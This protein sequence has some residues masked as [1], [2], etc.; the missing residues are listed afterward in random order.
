MQP[1]HQQTIANAER[2]FAA[3][4]NVI[5]LLVGG[6]LAHGFALERS[7]VDIMIIVTPEEYQ[8]RQ[9]ANELLYLDFENC[10]YEGG[11]ID[12][13]YVDL[14]YIELVAERGSE[15][16]RYAF[17]DA[18]VVF[19]RDDRVP[20]LLRRAAR[21]PVE[22]QEA[23]IRR[24]LGQLNAWKWMAQEGRKHAN[25]YLIQRAVD[26]FVLF[27]VRVILAHNQRL[28]PFH[29]WML[30]ELDHASDQPDGMRDR[31]DRILVDHSAEEMET[32]F[33]QVKATT[34]VTFNDAE[35][36]KWFLRDSEQ[37]WID[38]EP[39]VADL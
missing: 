8:R 34:T 37:N 25:R 5:A 17:K 30:R 24:F 32:L 2:I 26:N 35:W 23:N 38:H 19:S 39:P 4:K 11:Y 6:S 7:D 13:K 14:S 3:D 21:Y 10:T 15:P 31:I 27:S 36:G 20:E 29:K 1:H 33:E 22:H 28:Y 12:G 18:I 9:A 16:A